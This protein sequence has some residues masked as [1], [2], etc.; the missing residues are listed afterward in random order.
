MA[1]YVVTVS[2]HGERYLKNFNN[3]EFSTNTVFVNP[4]L[5]CSGVLNM[6]LLGVCKHYCVAAWEDFAREQ[7]RVFFLFFHFLYPGELTLLS[8]KYRYSLFK[9]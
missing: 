6:D 9:K 2:E 5:L 7:R 8:I 1:V 3:K 4:V